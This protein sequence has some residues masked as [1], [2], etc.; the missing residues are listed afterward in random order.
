[1][2]STTT[3]TPSVATHFEKSSPSVA[4]TYAALLKASRGLGQVREEPKKTSIHLV[5][6]TAFAGVA[7]RKDSL[8]LTLKA[9][10]K[11]DSPRIMRVEQ[12][13]ANRWHLEVRLTSP[14][15]IDAELR[16]WLSNAYNISS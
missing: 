13:S 10:H 7:T 3:G 12:T 14:A 11:I 1:M 8:I 4:A 2:P 16:L 15:D 9:D 6:K 5:R